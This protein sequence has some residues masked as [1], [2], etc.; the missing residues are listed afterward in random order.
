M[1]LQNYKVKIS[2]QVPILSLLV[3]LPAAAYNLMMFHTLIEG[4]T[5]VVAILTFVVAFNSYPFSHSNYLMFIGC[6]Y[7]W[8]GALDFCHTFSF[9]QFGIF[10]NIDASTTIQ[11]W[12][13]ARFLE[14]M[15][16]IA[17]PC[18]ISRTIHRKLMFLGFAIVFSLAFWLVFSGYMPESY[19]KEHGLT[20]FK[21][22]SEYFIVALLVIAI[23]MLHWHK[24]HFNRSIY[25]LLVLSI[26]LT[27]AAE[28]SFTLYTN[29][30]GLSLIIGHFFKLFSFWFLYIALV[31]ST[32]TQPFKKLSISSDTFNSLPDAIIVVDK[33][34][35][36]LHANK[37]ATQS[38]SM[39]ESIVNLHVHALFHT[40]HVN[41]E[42][43]P[44]CRAI[45]QSEPMKYQEVQRLQH[46]KEI[47]LTKIN[48]HGDQEMLLHVSRDITLRK[49]M[50]DKYQTSNRLY[51]ILRLTNQAII[52]SK[53][54]QDLLD[55]VCNISV[56]H[57]N[58]TM[59]WIGMIQDNKIVPISS[60]GNSS[61]YIDN[62]KIRLDDSKYSQGPIGISAKKCEIA[63]VNNINTDK[64]FQP[65]RAAAQEYGFNSLATIPI[66]QAEK[67]IGVFA[68]YSNQLNSFDTQ[69]LELLSSLS[70]DISSIISFIQ[71]ENQRAIAEEKLQHL[72]QAIEQSKSAIIICN[73]QG[74]VEYVN[75]FYYQL[76]GFSSDT[77]LSKSIHQIPREVTSI[78]VIQQ[79]WQQVLNGH[80][81]QD[82]SALKAKNNNTL[83]ATQTLSPIFSNGKVDRIVYSAKDNTELHNAQE[84]IGLLA[85][86][87]PLTALPNRRLYQDRFK[88]ALNRAARH[89]TKVALLYLDLD[90][91]KYINDSKGHDFGD[92]LLQHVAN[93]LKNSV[94]ETDTVARLGGDEFSIILNDINGNQDIINI[95]STILKNLN[96]P[97]KINKHELTIHSSIGI[98]IFPDDADSRE[99]LM[100]NADMA[101]YHAKAEGKNNFQFFEKFLNVRAHD[102]LK[103]EN[104]LKEAISNNRFEM[105]YQP[106]I[107]VKTGKISGVEALIRWFDDKGKAISP[108]DFITIA[109][110]S[111]LILDIGQWVINTVC[112]QY[113][114]LLAQGFPKVK[115]AINISA[116]QFK[117]PKR[118]LNEIETALESARLPSE[119]LQLELTESVLINDIEQTLQVIEQLKEHH[120]SFAIDDFGT[121]YSSLS[122]LKSFPVDIIK[123]DR[124]FVKDIATDNN[125]RAIIRA[126]NSMAHELDLKVL[127][128]GVEDKIQL[129]FLTLHQCD[130]I[131]GYYFDKPMTLD[132]LFK[133]YRT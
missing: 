20:A 76:T 53:N 128:E 101:M 86:Y 66:V 130:F 77:I 19:S 41:T 7:F 68:I 132:A 95:T 6:G 13:L 127:A 26:G 106:Q 25:N 102:R 93:T 112:Q 33:N 92:M 73:T 46:W 35:I 131:Q 89:K 70:D 64:A 99:T 48:Y 24:K 12:L 72:S 49:N 117:H 27:I 30:S 58:F 121:G 118:L 22:Y 114:Q 82:E 79:H 57:G 129:D 65:W 55:A 32:L 21:I 75:P 108:N 78:E 88:Q 42:N 104:N 116:V 124:S 115:I 60:A 87:D 38:Q 107:N 63:F 90:N 59:A 98:S 43:C 97:T 3:L 80:D 39:Y 5:I 91:F 44:I 105:Y 2:W 34:G 23:M 94:R 4:F 40:P 14:A 74:I 15:I 10:N 109:E 62:I 111:N 31:E 96:T 71:V 11:F 36:I 56:K 123:I 69:T 29:L 113:A 16:L 51:T 122:Y 103:M 84:T 8:V 126:I 120:I 67:C 81:W 119:L 83:W 110:E 17:F 28:I 37:S 50:Q 54:K 1:N 47:S 85:Y 9:A 45:Y 18:F 52:K 133:K 125:N 100:R 61:P